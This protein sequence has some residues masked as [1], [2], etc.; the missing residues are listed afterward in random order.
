MNVTPVSAKCVNKRSARACESIY[1]FIMACLDHYLPFR[2][3]MLC[4]LLSA[5][6]NTE[7]HAF[8]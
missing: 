3:N 2:V 8:M 6:E 7:S 5:D 1:L 4:L